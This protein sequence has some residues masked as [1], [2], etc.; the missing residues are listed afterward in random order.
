VEFANYSFEVA[1]DVI[2]SILEKK[3]DDRSPEYYVITV[4]AVWIYARPFTD[5]S[6]PE[7]SLTTLC[8]QSLRAC[9]TKL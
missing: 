1:R 9:T 4:G 2:Q 7:S 8:R 3:I 5:N 6:R